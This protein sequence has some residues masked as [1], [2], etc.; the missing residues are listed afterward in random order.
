MVE[1]DNGLVVI[2]QRVQNID[3]LD[4]F[5]MYMILSNCFVQ[6]QWKA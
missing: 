6:E 2:Y 1:L 5:C 3:E 4:A